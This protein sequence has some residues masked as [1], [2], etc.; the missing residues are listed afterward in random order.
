MCNYVYLMGYPMEV[1]PDGKYCPA[2]GGRIQGSGMYGEPT[3]LMRVPM[4][5]VD[6]T[7]RKMEELKERASLSRP[8]VENRF[9]TT[10][11]IDLNE[12][13]KMIVPRSLAHPSSPSPSAASDSPSSD[14][15]N[16][17]SNALQTEK[18]DRRAKRRE[19]RQKRS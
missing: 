2:P 17:P 6:E 12:A 5:L 9:Y 10:P 15:Q 11:G 18:R 16:A 13:L 1:L 7:K 14:A 4:S 3:I 19:K 8:T